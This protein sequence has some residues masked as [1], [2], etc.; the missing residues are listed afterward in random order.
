MNSDFGT[1]YVDGHPIETE[2]MIINNDVLIPFLFLKYAEINVNM[3]S[4][5]KQI[6]LN[7]GNKVLKLIINDRYTNYYLKDTGKWQK[8]LCDTIVINNYISLRF[9][10]EKLNMKFLYSSK[11]SRIYLI[12][13][14]CS[15]TKQQIIYRG[16]SFKNKVALTF[17]DGPDNTATLKILDILRDKGVSATF[18]VVGKQIKSFPQNLER[19]LSEGHQLGNHSFSHTTLT[20]LTTS[21]V[22]KEIRKAEEDIKSI[23]GIK[24]NIFRPSYGFVTN[25]DFQAISNLGYKVIGWNIDTKDYLGI[26]DDEIIKIVNRDISPGSIILQHSLE[27]KP[28]VLD[29][30]VKALPNII[31]KLRSQG[32]KLVTIENLLNNI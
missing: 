2:Y 7:K 15:A 21:Q 4:N 17:D 18:F 6:V 1:I 22:I 20:K 19:I 24:T 27:W 16:E 26:A 10:A 5:N 29:G 31:D 12:T 14:T 30:T 32:L 9:I 3:F 23:T 8:E 25:A 28:G 11:E 13:N